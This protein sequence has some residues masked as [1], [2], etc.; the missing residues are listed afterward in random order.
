[1]CKKK[2]LIKGLLEMQKMVE[3]AGIEPAS[4]SD[5]PGDLHA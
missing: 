3:A 1:M 5:T 2:D 4:A